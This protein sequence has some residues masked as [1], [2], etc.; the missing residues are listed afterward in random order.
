MKDIQEL[1]KA[2]TTE[3]GQVD[4]SRVTEEIN[5]EINAIVARNV[6]KAEKN[7]FKSLEIEGVEDSKT[8][9]SYIEARTSE[10]T[11]R[12]SELEKALL[13]KD[14][15]ISSFKTEVEQTRTK[16]EEYAKSADMLTKERILLQE[17]IVDPEDRDYFLHTVDKFV[18]ENTDFAAAWNR[19]KEEKPEK[20]LRFI[21]KDKPISTGTKTRSAEAKQLSGAKALLR[22]RN[23]ELFRDT[24]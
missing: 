17:G 1:I 24:E 5:N 3:E 14:E 22:E 16:L 7:A 12:M 6:D 10:P 21:A 2:H 23:P 18:D 15:V 8:L 9:L 19:Y 4:F 20:V 13:E 11:E